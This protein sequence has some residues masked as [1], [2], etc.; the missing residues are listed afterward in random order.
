[1]KFQHYR[2]IASLQEYILIAQDE[3]H[4]EHYTRQEPNQWILIEATG[5]DAILPISSISATLALADVYEQVD[6]PSSREPFLPRD[7]PPE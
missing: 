7:I 5:P 3:Q 2:T 4:I 1:M 6:P